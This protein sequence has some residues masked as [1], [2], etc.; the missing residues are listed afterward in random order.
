MLT[1]WYVKKPLGVKRLLWCPTEEY[2][3]TSCFCASTVVTWMH[4]CGTWI[5]FLVFNVEMYQVKIPINQSH[6]HWKKLISRYE[7]KWRAQ[8]EAR[9]LLY[10]RIYRVIHKSLRDARPLRYGSWDG[11][12]EGR[13]CQ[14]RERHSNFP[15]DS[16]PIDML[17]SAVSVC[18]GCCAAEFEVP[19][20][21]M[22]YSV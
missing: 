3:D 15:R 9:I 5:A 13:A 8:I 16:L 20:G 12:A 11:H 19:E 6:V 7:Q 10:N 4:L 17:L 1:W 2:C 22:N 18:L 14:Q 21:L